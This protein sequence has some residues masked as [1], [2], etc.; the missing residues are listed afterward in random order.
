M[1]RHIAKEWTA[2]LRSGITRQTRKHLGRNDGSR[3][4]LGV[5][6]DMAVEEGIIRFPRPFRPSK[7]QRGCLVF[8]GARHNLPPEVRDW[9]Q[10]K[11]NY[12]QYP[13]EI[14]T[15][16]SSTYGAQ[17]SLALD[18]DAG[19]NFNEIAETIEQYVDAL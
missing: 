7:T 19:A 11:T 5:L 3:C 6:C 1:N 14:G 2:R 13:G 18:N 17:P 10:M 15:G 4:C 8:A 9:A 16:R 12:G